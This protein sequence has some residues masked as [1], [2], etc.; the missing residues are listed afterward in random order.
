MWDTI[1]VPYTHIHTDGKSRSTIDHFF[2][3]PRLI[4]LVEAGGIVERGDNRSRHCPIWLKLKLG[5]LPIN[6]KVPKWIP[7]RVNWSKASHEQISS[8]KQ[9]LEYRICI[10]EQNI[11][12]SAD[13]CC[14]NPHCKLEV[15]SA[16][17]DDIMLD[18]LTA[19][20]ETSHQNI[21]C[22]KGGWSKKTTS[23]L[24]V[25]G[26]N[27]EVKLFKQNSMYWC[28][29]WR[30][31]GRLTEGWLVESYKEARRQYHY[32][33]MRV[34]RDRQKHQAEELLCAAMHGDVELLKEMKH[35][36]LF[37]NY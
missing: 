34:K 1:S 22:N 18:I 35:R 31:H 19:I 33:V 4:P 3:S 26:W 11:K 36:Q 17:H 25:P 7:S 8:F 23:R 32:A 16:A 5:T 10:L 27:S 20:V 37:Y 9:N 24:D 14:D 29:L 2:V 6:E 30:T 12:S 15:H 21:P 13:F 28:N